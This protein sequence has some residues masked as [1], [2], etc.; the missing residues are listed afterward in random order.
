[1]TPDAHPSPDHVGSRGALVQ[2]R[3]PALR[4]VIRRTLRK[5]EA[6]PGSAR[7]RSCIVRCGEA[8]GGAP[9]QGSTHGR[10]RSFRRIAQAAVA[11]SCRIGVLRSEESSG[12]RSG[13]P[14]PLRGAHDSDRASCVAAKREA[15]RLGKAPREADRPAFAESRSQLQRAHA[16]SESCAPDHSALIIPK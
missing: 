7:L 13:K 4:R 10:S 12:E 6:A 11:A 5:T 15:G 16:G 14:R 8:G 2:D 3:S 9:R 1:V